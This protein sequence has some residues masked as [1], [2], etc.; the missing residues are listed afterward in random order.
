MTETVETF[1]VD[2]N[3]VQLSLAAF[4]ALLPTTTIYAEFA[5]GR[6]DTN[7]NVAFTRSA[8]MTRTNSGRWTIAFD[9]SHPDGE[10]YV[11]CTTAEEESGNRD[12]PDITVVQGSMTANGF[13]LQ[14]VTGDNGGTADVYVDTPFQWSVSGPIVV[15][16]N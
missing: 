15:L 9:A 4:A 12:T 8:T 6:S 5:A 10:D 2:N 3:P 7:T 1:D 16:T 14:I 13:D 11:V